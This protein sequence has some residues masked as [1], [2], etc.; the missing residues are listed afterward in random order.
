MVV[1]TQAGGLQNLGNTCFMNAV[2]Q[3]LIH[4][5][6]MAELF[7]AS[8]DLGQGN[9]TNPVFMTQQLVRR[10]FGGRDIVVPS[11]HAK[12]LKLFNKK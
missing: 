5:P 3:C 9:P 10:A 2:L 6:P 4:T 12:G 8:F 7:L 1:A 11:A